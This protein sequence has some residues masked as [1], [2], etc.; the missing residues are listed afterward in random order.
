MRLHG[1]FALAALLVLAG[2]TVGPDYVRP[3]VETPAAF[4]EGWK[5]A[6]PRDHE[7]RGKWWEAFAD[8]L[9]NGA[10]DVTL[11]QDIEGVG[12]ACAQALIELA[13]DRSRERGEDVLL[14]CIP[15]ATDRD[16]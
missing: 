7:N 1:F 9:L 4:K 15:R 6:E 5:Q 12:R 10:I 8:P 11:T 13:A 2:C 14:P 16:E 3:E